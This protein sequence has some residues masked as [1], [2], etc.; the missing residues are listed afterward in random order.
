MSSEQRGFVFG[1]TF[2]VIFATLIA[3][4]PP[5]LFGPG[6]TPDMVIP[7]D[8]SLITDFSE[9]E[10]YTKSAF[11]GVPLQYTY[12][13]GGREW[14]CATDGAGFELGAKVKIFGALWLGALDLVRFV[15]SSGTDRGDLLTIDEIEA[16]ATDGTI[17]YSLTYTTN[18]NSAGGFVVYW[19][20][21][22][23][24]DPQD[25]WTA[26][27]L[28][29]LHGM[30]I[31]DTAVMNAVQLLISLLFL[32]LPD[33]PVLVNLLIAVPLWAS[34]IFVIWFLIKESMPFV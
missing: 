8:P 32:Q 9:A 24:S 3:A 6:E 25:A 28:Y 2:I 20:T 17:R 16:D 19:N 26:D 5:G 29:L 4:M 7:V 13:L 18:G 21:T 34:I 23:Y 12:T 15:S 27:E 31:E 30:G 10:N 11:A 14:I 22:E 1:V 33:V